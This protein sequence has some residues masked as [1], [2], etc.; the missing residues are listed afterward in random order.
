LGIAG[1][2]PGEV[3]RTEVRRL[4][5]SVEVLAACAQTVLQP[6]EAVTVV[7][8]TPGGYGAEGAGDD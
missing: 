1:G 7:T 4:D 3:G 6:G 5:G 2:G 8:P